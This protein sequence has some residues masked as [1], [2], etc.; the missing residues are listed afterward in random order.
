[1]SS[2]TT[3]D[4]IAAL[5]ALGL[6]PEQL[7]AVMKL[8]EKKPKK[9][10][11]TRRDGE[12]KRPASSYMMWLKDNREK[13]I[14]DHFS[15]V[16]LVGRE[17]V[18]LVGKKAGEI[19]KSMSD[20]EKTPW[21]KQYAAAREVYMDSRPDGGA[22][23]SVAF[24][25]ATKDTEETECPD[26]W[27]GP[28]KVKYLW[29]YAVGR[30]RGVGNFPTLNEAVAE[31]NRLGDKCG[32]ITK[33][34]FGYTL[35]MGGE[36]RQDLNKPWQVSWLKDNY[37]G[38]VKSP[39]RSP[40]PKRIASPIS[41]SDDNICSPTAPVSKASETPDAES[42]GE[43]DAKENEDED[44]VSDGDGSDEESEDEIS[45]EP[46]EYKGTTYLLDGSTNVVYDYESQ[47]E[48]GKLTKNG[49]LKKN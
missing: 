9:L 47:E 45:V 42:D 29:G 19:W 6:E 34:K 49:K 40:S 43:S 31:A 8:M 7:A 23:N 28:H 22:K 11:K 2:A 24:D 38:A 10:K 44:E 36:L 35:R 12:P 1:M 14:L 18:T 37:N 32:G 27:N 17:K 33:E 21:L 20:E 4:S 13:I 25:F 3:A 39:K 41:V 48:I 26:G 5:T 15:D 30:S 46:W 16:E